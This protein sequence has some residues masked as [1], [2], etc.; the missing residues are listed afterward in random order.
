MSETQQKHQKPVARPWSGPVFGSE[1]WKYD[2][3]FD[4]ERGRICH[5]SMRLCRKR[6]WH[7]D[8]RCFFWRAY[9]ALRPSMLE[10][11]R[12]WSLPEQP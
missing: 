7:S 4:H 6:G 8:K 5:S 3:G 2:T 10:L 11:V 9:L 12:R 1:S